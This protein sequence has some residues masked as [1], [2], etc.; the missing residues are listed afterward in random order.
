VCLH[1]QLEPLA[2]LAILLRT[3]KIVLTSRGV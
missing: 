3:V 1:C 2:D